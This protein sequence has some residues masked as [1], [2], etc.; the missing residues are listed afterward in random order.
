MLGADEG[1]AQIL[2][3]RAEKLQPR[4]AQAVLVAALSWTV[5]GVRPALSWL[6]ATVVVSLIDWN[7]CRRLLAAPR[8]RATF[9]LVCVSLTLSA[10]AFSSI[11][12]LLLARPAVGALAEAALILC[13]T[14]LNNALMTKSSPLGA[15]L[16]LG[17]SSLVLLVTPIAAGV[18][19]HPLKLTDAVLLELGAIAYLVF[20]GRLAA[21]LNGE[22]ETVRRALE[23]QDRQRR[24]AEFAMEEAV[25]SRARWRMLFDQSPLPQS[26]FNASRLHEMLRP[27]ID[28]GETCL[29]DVARVL[30][31][32]KA[33]ALQF[34][35]LIDSNEAAEALFE[36]DQFNA[37]P[38]PNR[39]HDSFF[40]KFCEGLNGVDEDGVL[41]PF[42]TKIVRPSGEAIDVRV[43]IRM[44][45]G[46]EPPWS[47][48]MTSYVDMTQTRQAARAQQAAV[49]A[50]ESAN[51]AKSEFLAVM[52]HEIR[53]PLNGVL[54][55]AQAME[56]E[57][58]SKVQ[59]G[60]LGIIRQSGAA[61]LEIL[62]DVLDLSKIEA[63]KLELEA[64]DFDL[65]AL[66]RA[67]Q[68]TFDAIA[69]RKKLN[70]HVVV[71]PGAQGL[72]R[73]D[74]VRVR[75]VIYN[76]LANAVKFTE[77]GEVRLEISAPGGLVRIIVRDTGVGIES[78][79]VS[80]LFE[81]FVQ[82]DSSTT[83]R[84]GG[85]GLGLAICR[86]LCKAMEGSIRVESELGVGSLFVVELPLARA[87]A[88]AKP[89]G[90]LATV[91]RV[92][93]T[94]AHPSALRVL[95]AEDNPI[96]QLVLKTLLAQVGVEPV[97]VG[98]G[99]RAVAA[100][101]ECDW[102][103]VLMDVQMP[104]MD[105]PSAA[106]A[107]RAAEAASG[108]TPTPIIALTANAMSHQVE[109]YRAAGM[110]GILAKPIE[111]AQLYAALAAAEDRSDE[112]EVA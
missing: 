21:T 62:N 80:R 23:D 25:N 42:E 18:L 61:L 76:L 102:D 40:E 89:I 91:P 51:R 65:E 104:V 53:T 74:E 15:A 110:D 106:R 66:A 59:R 94:S 30:F 58:L 92:A 22:G 5:I 93:T 1:F 37:R 85:T 27:H 26:C 7:L 75:Q 111:V 83:R 90:E 56:H 105:G 39:V 97:I 88:P 8:A 109:A 2:R 79:R 100:F 48:C 24:R 77:R 36:V 103:L 52:S 108:A 33:E 45:P 78:E 57:P 98:D 14:N 6:A 3:W 96:N 60:R 63:G 12:I 11:A 99:A 69:A 47:V 67:A 87:A 70:L 95:A 20:I 9:V 112:R 19:G 49:E 101:A 41:A 82:A 29:G 43:H 13:A 54:G 28:V 38:N 46:Q 31:A 10:A 68:A 84:F 34:I 50:A 86:E 73:G 16:I 81:K 44:P 32:A 71:D 4:F 72:Y 55:M 64:T 107:I 35:T 17:P